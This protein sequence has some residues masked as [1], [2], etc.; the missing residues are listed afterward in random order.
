VLGSPEEVEADYAD[1]HIAF[2]PRP[3]IGK[4]MLAMTR[5]ILEQRR[6]AAA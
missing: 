4:E 3:V 6:H 2:L 1:E 5:S